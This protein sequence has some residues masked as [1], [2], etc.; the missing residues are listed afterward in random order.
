MPAAFF[1][2]VI[3]KKG[4][5]SRSGIATGDSDRAGGTAAPVPPIFTSISS[6]NAPPFQTQKKSG[7]TF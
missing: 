5:R 6:E 3:A 2:R 4:G 1:V 7:E